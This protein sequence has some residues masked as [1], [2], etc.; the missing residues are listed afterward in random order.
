MKSKK[1]TV[2]EEN[3]K[4]NVPSVRIY[5][6]TFFVLIILKLVKNSKNFIIL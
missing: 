1:I 6:L 2:N 5:F 3:Q 4:S